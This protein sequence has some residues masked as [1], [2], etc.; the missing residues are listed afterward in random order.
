MSLVQLLVFAPLLAVPLLPL[1]TGAVL[2]W[3]PVF[4][5][6]LPVAALVPGRALDLSWVMLGAG[7]VPAMAAS[8]TVALLAL[9]FA[10]A[11]W[12]RAGR[13]GP[14]GSACLLLAQ[15]A[16]GAALVASDLL[17][18]L[19]GFT[20]ATYTLLAARLGDGACIPGRLPAVIAVLVLGDLAAFE[21]ALLLAKAA[22]NAVVP[23][24][25]GAAGALSASPF[26]AAFA[27]LAAGSRGGLLLLAGFRS[28]AAL[29]LVALPL[30]AVPVLGWRL[31]GLS[32]VAGAL[33]AVAAF[34]LA[35]AGLALLFRRLLPRLA[36][37]LAAWQ[38]SAFGLPGQR[39]N[40]EPSST[41]ARRSG[42]L[43]AGLGTLE[44][45]VGSWGLALAGTVLLVL[46]L[47]AATVR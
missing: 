20:L 29:P 38:V 28:V 47:L 10:L 36:P 7:T 23:T 22:D 46:L 17:L 6:L 35:A 34:A 8:A 25:A 3:L 39:A 24:V 41:P 33:A 4:A 12:M 16:L 13:T 40:G 21:L 32:A 27:L 1:S 9:C 14:Y 19:A 18:L 42:G 45:A 26:V 37:R 5:A 15:G 44:L 11:L 2:R 31:G 43:A 30:L